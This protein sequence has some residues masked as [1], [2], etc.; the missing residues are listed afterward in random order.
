MYE[1]CIEACG[2]ESH[3]A[4]LSADYCIPQG[5]FLGL[6][7][8]A[9]WMICQCQMMRCLWCN[10]T[11]YRQVTACWSGFTPSVTTSS[12]TYVVQS[13]LAELDQCINTW[14]RCFIVTDN[15]CP[16]LVLLAEHPYSPADQLQPLWRCCHCRNTRNWIQVTQRPVSTQVRNITRKGCSTSSHFY[17]Q[18]WLL[19]QEPQISRSLRFCLK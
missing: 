7:F 2:K 5:T 6:F 15:S 13:D 17:L 9:W 16:L 4:S 11:N 1:G 3:D 12:E 14:V 19:V 18:L 10:C 8:S